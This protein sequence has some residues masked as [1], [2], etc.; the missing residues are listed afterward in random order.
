MITSNKMESVKK[1]LPTN[2]SPGSPA[3]LAKFIKYLKKN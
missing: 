1:N 3:S 2:E